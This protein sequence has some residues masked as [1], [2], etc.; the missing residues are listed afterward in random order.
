M[1]T[2]SAKGI[3]KKLD[4]AWS[5]LVKLKAGFKCE[6]CQTRRNLQS[7]HIF[8]R[9]KKSTRWHVPNGV[10]LCASHHTLNSSFSAHKTGTEFTLW[11][12]ETKGKNFMD[13][14]RVKAN[15]TSKLFKFEKELLLKELEKEI[16][17]FGVDYKKYV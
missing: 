2:K 15:S 5:L 16:A 9:S 13:I 6:Y 10:C 8:S 3:D 17:S 11:L 7:H 12:Y 4:E 1:K 14:L